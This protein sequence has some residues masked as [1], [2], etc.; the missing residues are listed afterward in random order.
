MPV[1]AKATVR[2]AGQRQLI[3]AGRLYADDDPV[4]D[5]H[6]DLFESTEEYRRRKAK[7]RS[8]ADLGSRSVSAWRT[9]VETATAEPGEKRDIGHRCLE[10]GHVSTSER[11]LRVHIS[12]NHGR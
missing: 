8:T 12:R 9:A 7:P 1:V 10:C 2:V 5:S 3:I 4:V 11:G 6:P